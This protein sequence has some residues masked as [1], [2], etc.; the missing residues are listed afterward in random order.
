VTRTAEVVVIGA[1]VMGASVAYH[2]AARGC[3]DVL[4]LERSDRAGLGSTGRAMGGF[5]GQ[6][7]TDVCVRLSLL[8]REK[9]LRF[10]D[11]LG[12]DPGYRP[13]GYLFMART[14][15]QLDTLRAAHA[16]QRRAGL[17]QVR[18][19]GSDEIP[20]LSTAVRADRY[21]GGS[22]CPTDGYIVPL[23]ILRGYLGGAQR[24]GVTIEYG[25]GDVACLA[26]DSGD[27]TR[28]VRGVRTRR[29]EVAARHVVNAAGPWAAAVGRTA[30]IEVPVVPARRQVA[31]TAPCALSA[32]TP[33]TIDV[34]DGVHY[35]VRD[36]R[37]VLMWPVDTPA[38]DPFDTTFDPRWLDALLPRAY[39]MAPALRDAGIDP[40][41][42]LCGLYEMS[43]DKH[44]ILGPAPGV[45][46]LYLINGSSGHGVMHST[47]LGQLL[48]EII[49]DG[50]AHSLDVH[51]LRPSRFAEGEPNLETGVL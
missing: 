42:C 9:L 36:G 50:R 15:A 48:A 10:R 37:V 8:A 21:V 14:A 26:E 29:G 23:D 20:R 51:A 19:V 40:D 41:A 44:A 24:L 7:A 22:F 27:G 30:G 28:R 38:D 4:V 11:E 47:A 35:R 6:F 32:D 33:M 43:P 5:R 46:G 25:V 34:D 1:G 45:R 39:A 16:V 12:V 2:L 31:I 13:V 49:V 3:R 18:E 17:H